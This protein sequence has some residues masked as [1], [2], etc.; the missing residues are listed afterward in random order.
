MST[1]LNLLR[2]TALYLL[3]TLQ[4]N[5]LILALGVLI[6]GALRVYLD[7]ERM[8]QWLLN[9]SALSIPATV[10]FGAFTPFCACGTMAVVLGMLASSLPWGAIMAFLTSSPLMSPDEFVL[11]SGILGLRFA[12]ALTAASVLIGVGSGYVANLFQKKTSFFADQFRFSAP[13]KKASPRKVIVTHEE[14]RSAAF[15]PSV[16]YRN[17]AS[18][19]CCAGA[20]ANVCG[21][22]AET[23]KP[24]TPVAALIRRFR[25][26]ELAET[27]FDIGIKKILPLFVAFA[28]VGYL[29][30]RFVPAAWISAVFGAKNF[31]AVP[32]AAIVGLPLYVSGSAAIPLM[33]SLLQ[34][35]VSPGAMLAFMITGPGT[36][37]GVIA[38]IA[39]I[40]KRRAIAFYLVCLMVGAIVL[41]YLYDFILLLF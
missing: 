20:Q 35:G 7:A 12:I 8:K 17:A 6:A 34:A 1:I 16:S 40:L 14:M 9:R 13:A 32:I 21:A 10:A 37:A 2:D 18:S 4:H 28:A 25:L 24:A 23:I 11:I 26:D 33:D 36:S 39:S 31:F 3:Q 30:N 41:G 27:I 15:V 29:I 5:A 19:A 38:G 22:T